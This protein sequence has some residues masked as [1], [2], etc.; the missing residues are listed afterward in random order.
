MMAELAEHY[1]QRRGELQKEEGS[2]IEFTY[3]CQT[4]PQQSPDK[5]IHLDGWTVVATGGWMVR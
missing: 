2:A 3:Y 4:A 1:Y 5:Q